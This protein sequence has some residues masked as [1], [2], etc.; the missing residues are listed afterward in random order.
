MGLVERVLGERLDVVPHALGQPRVVAVALSALTQSA[1][2][3]PRTSFFFL[4]MALRSLSALAAEKPAHLHG[5][6]HDLLLVDHRAVRLF[7]DRLEPLV[8]VG[9]LATTVLALDEVIDHA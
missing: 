6:A 7:E 4:P 3:L 9:D 8:V 5:D 2:S 1:L